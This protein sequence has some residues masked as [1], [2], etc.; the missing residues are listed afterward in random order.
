[1]QR[2]NPVT[3]SHQQPIAPRFGQFG[4]A[5]LVR[6][7]SIYIWVIRFGWRRPGRTGRKAFLF[8]AIAKKKDG[9]L[10]VGRGRGIKNTRSIDLRPWR[11]HA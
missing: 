8:R 4:R 6:V 10:I 7:R 1:M 5:Q 3:A 11:S 2:V 9:R